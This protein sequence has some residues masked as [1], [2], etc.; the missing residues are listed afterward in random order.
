[1]LRLVFTT[2]KKADTQL[3]PHKHWCRLKMYSVFSG[4]V[5]KPYA[6]NAISKK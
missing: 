1:M 6:K 2:D 4:N 3:N 5:I